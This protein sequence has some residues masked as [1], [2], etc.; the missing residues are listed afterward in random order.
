MF[1]SKEKKFWRWFSKNIERFNEFESDVEGNLDLLCLK[2]GK[3]HE[4]IVPE[5]L[6]NE[7]EEPLR[8]REL[9][10]SADGIKEAFPAVEKLVKCAPN[11]PGWQIIAF[12]QRKGYVIGL[13]GERFD[14][15]NVF[16]SLEEDA[17]RPKTVG[18]TM[19]FAGAD[20]PEDSRIQKACYLIL[21][22]CLGEYEVETKVGYVTRLIL[23]DEVDR[24]KLLT[25]EQFADE[26]DKLFETINN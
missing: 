11:I 1:A 17:H 21:D 26:F 19:Y 24:A 16:I 12:R 20:D 13:A 23:T 6:M 4:C 25:L 14:N 7:T 3:V 5:L 10:I 9:I 2:L 8:E 15:N 18:I 22:G